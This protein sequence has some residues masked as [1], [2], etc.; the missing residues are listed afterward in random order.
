VLKL[1][2]R[3]DAERD[4]AR[5]QLADAVK[6]DANRHFIPEAQL[7]QAL[8]L[9]DKPDSASQQEA[10]Q[11]LKDY[12]NNYQTARVEAWKYGASLPSNMEI[13]YDY[14]RLLGETRWKPGYPEAP[15]GGGGGMLLMAGGGGGAAPGPFSAGKYNSTAKPK[16]PGTR[17][18]VGK[19][20][21]VGAAMSRT[22]GALTGAATTVAPVVTKQ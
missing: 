22:G 9:I 6:L 4:S 12:I 17:Q 18:A 10:V 11:A 16:V 15:T 20:V 3:T 21:G 14:M 7:Q 1:V 2:A 5:E 13:L 19:A 8:L